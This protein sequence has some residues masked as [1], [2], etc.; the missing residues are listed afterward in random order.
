MRLAAASEGLAVCPEAAACIGAAEQ[1]AKQGWIR[2][3]E[4]VVVFNTGAAQK[5]VEVIR[6]VVP[7][8]DRTQPIDWGALG[9]G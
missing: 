6:S 1:L 7:T 3:D 2:P 4:R 9:L 5:Y 8:L